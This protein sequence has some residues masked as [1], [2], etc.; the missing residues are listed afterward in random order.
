MKSIPVAT[1]P[2]MTPKE[3]YGL[4]TGDFESLWDSLSSTEN[5]TYR[6]NFTFALLDMVLLEYIS[7]A[8]KQDQTGDLLRKFTVSLDSSDKRYFEVIN[9]WPGL[10]PYGEYTIPYKT[11][12]GKEVL[13]FLFDLIRNG[14]AHQ[15]QQII[16]NLKD[17][18]IAIRI[19]GAEFGV[20]LN[21]V[22]SRSKHLDVWNST[23]NRKPLVLIYFRPEVFY[24]DLK[25]AVKCSLIF[26]K[27]TSFN[28]LSRSYPT[29]TRE[30]FLKSIGMTEGI[31]K[32]LQGKL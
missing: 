8:C 19:S 31:S 30:S 29:I 13:S 2:N 28:Y 15:Y 3:I 25:T 17:C 22:K 4:I 32:A 12:E 14:Q 6:G 23:N 27:V 10:N 5:S 20:K 1:P 11:Q 7:R 9:G 26:D 16:A 24:L 21:T 18:S